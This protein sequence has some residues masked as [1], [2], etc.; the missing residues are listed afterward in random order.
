M[1]LIQSEQRVASQIWRNVIYLCDQYFNNITVLRDVTLFCFVDRYRRFGITRY[2]HLEGRRYGGSGFLQNAFTRCIHR[3]HDINKVLMFI[4]GVVKT[5]SVSLAMKQYPC[6][7]QCLIRHNREPSW[8]SLLECR[9]AGKVRAGY[10]YTYLMQ[11]VLRKLAVKSV[12]VLLRV[13]DVPGLKFGLETGYRDWHSSW[14]SSVP[15]DKFWNRPRWLPFTFLTIILPFNVQSMIFS[16]LL[17]LSFLL[18][19]LILK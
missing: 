2:H 3:D 14:F 19:I 5:L 11:S 8:Y 6:K 10:T 7:V 1:D 15:K 16:S 13:K 18:V 4:Y 12:T 17:F 9:D